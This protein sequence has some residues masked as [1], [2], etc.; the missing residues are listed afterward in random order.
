MVQADSVLCQMNEWF[1]L[2]VE[3]RS[4]GSGVIKVDLRDGQRQRKWQWQRNDVKTLL[5]HEKSNGGGLLQSHQSLT[6]GSVGV[7]SERDEQDRYRADQK[8]H[9]DCTHFD[10]GVV[11][12]SLLEFEK[13]QE[14]V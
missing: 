1:E 7:G 5:L 10:A 11:E 6:T 8:T 12:S 13:R 9:R 14:S 3:Q 4:M 2:E